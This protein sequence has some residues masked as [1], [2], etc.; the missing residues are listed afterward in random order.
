MINWWDV[1][2]SIIG[3]TV[4]A[5]GG[6]LLKRV[7]RMMILMES[8]QQHIIECRIIREEV[9]RRL[10][11]LERFAHKRNKDEPND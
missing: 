3:G 7:D 10:E 6:L 9:A 11:H 1:T 4:L 2:A 8:F 5:I